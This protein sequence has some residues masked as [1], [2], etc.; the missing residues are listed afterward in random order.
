[1]T[2]VKGGGT[3]VVEPTNL[4][5]P[6]FGAMLRADPTSF[7]SCDF[8]DDDT[9]TSPRWYP[10]S[11][12]TSTT[13]SPSPYLM[14]PWNPTY[15][16]YSKSPWILSSPMNNYDAGSGGG[17]GRVGGCDNINNFPQNSL[18]RSLVREEGHIYSLAV[19]GDLLYT[20]SDSRNIRV[21]KNLKGYAGFKSSSGLVKA[22]VISGEK[23]FTGHQDGKIRVWKSSRKDPSYHKRIGS[24][25]T[26]KDFVKNSTNPK[27]YVKIRR[28][29]KSLRIKHY[30]AVSSLS[31]DEAEGLLY[32]GSWDKTL[33]VWRIADFKCLESIQAHDD[34]VNSVAAGFQCFAF[35]GSADGTVKMWR[36]ESTWEGKSGGIKTKHVLDR[37]LLRQENAVTALA[38]NG[39]STVLYCGSSDG[40][41]NLW[42]LDWKNKLA[43]GGVLKG[44]KM[45][46]LCLAAGRN[47]VFSGSADK[48]VCVWK[49]EVN[50]D[51]TCLSVLTGHTGP[52]KC[53]AAR[54][55]E[56]EYP[57]RRRWTVYTG[58]LDRSVKVWRVWSHSAQP[59]VKSNNGHAW[60]V[61]RVGVGFPSPMSKSKML[62]GTFYWRMLKALACLGV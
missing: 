48:K 6:K 62:V 43:H 13:A 53:I 47:L 61:E 36:R 41:V 57:Q 59:V 7:Y 40:L 30:D 21:W 37:V 42:E 27:N 46:V 17:G 29:K 3:M 49:R 20:G 35:T 5:R 44:H 28:H 51:H 60:S 22:I 9:S 45:A 33:K 52:V 10:D 12:T 11:T 1:M 16:P 15:S 19:S 26:F 55:E 38:V 4:H 18:I 2:N 34:A 23:I 8:D 14:S 25:P 32:S 56:E 54:E 58:S 50:G 24:L 39:S 31:L